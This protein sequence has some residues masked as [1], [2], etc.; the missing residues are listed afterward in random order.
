MEIKRGLAFAIFVLFSLPL[1]FAFPSD[2][3]SHWDFNGNALDSAGNYDGVANGI[4]YG[5]GILGQ[6]ALFNGSGFVNFGDISEL[7]S[8]SEF[9]IVGWIKDA[10][11]DGT[12]TLFNKDNGI[13]D[14]IFSSTFLSDL[15]FEVGNSGNSY[16]YWDGYSSLIPENVW[17]HVAFV[18]DGNAATNAQKA[19]LY[20][21]GVQQ[22][23]TFSGVFPSQTADLF[24][25]DFTISDSSTPWNGAVDEVY[26][27]SRALTGDEVN[28]LHNFLCGNGRVDSGEDCEDG[29][30]NNYD[31]CNNFCQ[32][33]LRELELET[34]QGE[35]ELFVYH[36]TPMQEL[37]KEFITS[38][39]E[40]YVMTRAD[41]ISDID[42]FLNNVLA[43]KTTVVSTPNP[44][45][46]KVYQVDT[47]PGDVVRVQDHS[48]KD[49]RAIQG[50]LTQDSAARAIDVNA[51]NIVFDD[52][53]TNTMTLASGNYDFVVFDKYSIDPPGFVPD[54][55]R[56]TV[57]VENSLN[58]IIFEEN[59]TNP[60]PGSVE[61]VVV[62]SYAVPS[63]G[64]YEFLIDT[65]DSV[66][67]FLQE[68]TMAPCVDEDG[69]GVCDEDDEC[70]N[71]LPN[72]PVDEDG[73]DP[74]QFCDQFYCGIDCF[75][76][77][78]QNN[79]KDEFP[80][81]C[82]VVLRDVEGMQYPA[83]R[84]T[85]VTDMCFG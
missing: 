22:P 63:F 70:P 67:W 44:F 37:Q 79:E 61:G 68:C 55:R 36:D 83:C 25:R 28:E 35:A 84:P 74:F 41:Y 40:L 62:D 71:S 5:S 48:I 46:V 57:R 16:S 20:S 54:N 13:N 29:N 49:S 42:V 82:T 19:K 18:F 14:D 11:Q 77:D 75:T 1:V 10:D 59:Y 15:Y 4:S 31:E 50:I 7:N 33:G 58:N 80:G 73:C 12:K 78:F 60:S 24:G 9:T 51:F 45:G 64:S 17:T 56:L 3:L 2:Y 53:A 8:A 34:C 81:D 21:N 43:S 69:D 6:A 39:D 65:E 85:V 26:V 72:E 52:T 27:Y 23:L 38:R 30:L 66:Y 76:A 47:T 32:W